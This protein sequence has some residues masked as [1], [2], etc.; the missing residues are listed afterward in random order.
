MEVVESQWCQEAS[1]V[2]NLMASDRLTYFLT[3]FL[4]EWFIELHVAAKNSGNN[5]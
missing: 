2:V 4:T 5:I 3:S 1:K